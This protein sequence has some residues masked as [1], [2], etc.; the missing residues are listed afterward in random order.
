MTAGDCAGPRAAERE[1]GE[2][3]R[4]DTALNGHL[5][6][7]IGLVPIG[8]LDDALRQRLHRLV[9]A[10]ALGKLLNARPR[11]LAVQRDAAADQGRRCGP[12][13]SWRP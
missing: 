4:I 10:E 8:D 2:V 6:D 3:T 1:Q 9:R 7:A 13:P 12:A 5:P 11:P